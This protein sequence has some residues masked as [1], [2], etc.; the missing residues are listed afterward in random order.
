MQC[1]IDPLKEMAEF[2]EAC[3]SVKKGD[4][5]VLVT[6]LGDGVK[7]N[8]AM[9]LAKKTN[10]RNKVFVTY[11]EQR[12]RELKEDL[13]LYDK[14]AIIYP[15]KD[16]MFFAADV[17]GSAIV[18]ARL[19]VM[20]RLLD[21]EAS[22]II[23]TFD[24][25]LLKVLPVSDVLDNILLLKVGDTVDLEGIRE[26]LTVLGYENVAQVAGKGQFSVRGG[27][28]DI[29]SL[30]EDAPVRIELWGDEIDNI[31][32]FDP[33]S[34][35]S[36]DDGEVTEEISIYP[37][38]EMILDKKRSEKGIRRITKEM[39]DRVKY[40]RGQMKTEQA[41][42]LRDTVNEFKDNLDIYKGSFGTDSYIN[43]FYDNTE[44]FFDYFGGDTIFFLDEPARITEMAEAVTTEFRESMSARLEGGYILSGQAD[45]LWD[46]KRIFA[47]L[48]RRKTV[49]LSLI[50]TKTGAISAARRLDV[51]A[52][53]VN[54][55]NND[56]NLLVKDIKA[57][58]KSKSRVVLVSP[59]DIRAE[60][61]TKELVENDVNAVFTKDL[62][63]VPMPGETVCITGNL[64]RGFEYPLLGFV[65]ISESD[66]FGSE[67]KKRKKRK[68]SE[69]DNTSITSFSELHVGDF[70]IHENHG[71][72]IY[73][74]I[75]KIERDGVTRDYLKIEYAQG[76]S[77]FVPVSG[78]DLISKYA[79]QGSRKPHITDLGSKEW[80]KT[81]SKVRTSVN[82]IAKD[83]VE[84]Y[85]KRQNA[86]GYTFSADTVWQAEFE[87]TF[88]YEE[89]DDQLNAIAD[90]KRD[91]E[92]PKV[93]DRL[94]CGD[95]GFGKT[96]I[97]IRAA[98]KAVMDG[99]QVA[100]LVPTTIL[101]QQHYNTFIQRMREFPVKIDILSRFRTPKEVKKVKEGL[102]GGS[103]DIVVG[104]HKLLGK[105]MQFKDLGLLIVD[106]EQRFGVTHKEKIKKMRENIDVLT[107][108]A[109]PIP[110]TLHMSLSGIRDMSVLEEAPVDRLPIQTYVLEHNDEIIREAINRE[111]ARNGQVYYVYNRVK[112]IEDVASRV[113]NMVPEANVA[114]AHGQMT[115]RELERIMYDFINGDIDVL[116]STTIIETGIDI[117]NVNT[118]IIDDADRMGLSQLYQL[119]GRVGRSTRT[120]FAFMMYKRDKML[121]EV[122]EKRLA[123]IKE[124]TDLGSGFKIAM[125]DLE[126]RGAGNLLGKSQSGHME[127]VGYDLYCK[128]LND[129]VRKL[130]GEKVF[131]YDY[132]TVMNLDV[133][134]FIPA[135]YIR[136][137]T[138]KLE[139][140]KRIAAVTNGEELLD[141]KD[142]LIDRYG[143]LPG[144]V[145]NLTVVSYLRFMAHK[146]YITEVNMNG[147]NVQ[148]TM[149]EKADIDTA[150][151]A[152]FV[153]DYEGRLKVKKDGGSVKFTYR[154]TADVPEKGMNAKKSITDER[155]TELRSLLG[156]FLR[157]LPDEKKEAAG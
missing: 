86:A 18:S 157:L 143:D 62:S 67:K 125:R 44:S 68:K 28:I 25:G 2:N 41:A 52:R 134:A 50:E 5:P 111:L 24:A 77:L 43:Y 46:Y 71:L 55:Y 64:K 60:R 91:M 49:L 113:A 4:G 94:I 98:F 124:F 100:L 133:D 13:Q 75:E 11:S 54:P 17:H 35:R 87:N 15:A 138:L 16:L 45:L 69:S 144:C 40:L 142:E 119:R 107:L 151:I 102:L 153:D 9:A 140:Y 101:A 145:D 7:A 108:S 39:E 47:F 147:K 149:F 56:F 31:R 93:M 61:I 83:L 53:N 122:A 59:N 85:A 130:K 115:Q 99:K 23:L 132:E 156:D 80:T 26:A 6:G 116:I 105:D 114:F 58:K 150:K 148:I 48:S 14:K 139:M 123:A 65:V 89:T 19:E 96:E 128:M 136:N 120:S 104:T 88:P 21:N 109:T 1:F 97:A 81:K 30:T 84:L 103:I 12:A 74:G 141:I 152:P 8:F 146:A 38:S 42:R 126:I 135:S 70:V 155:L 29:F 137:E 22:T 20:K 34:Q 82:E 121:R 10:A 127:T 72:G 131:G 92:S 3:K 51:T 95:V 36:I 27:L 37:A 110:R 32:Y 117:S 66:I 154:L 57:Y 106:E 33:E 73:K 76:A 118:I 63:R 112:G 129:A 78:L 79:G 90:V